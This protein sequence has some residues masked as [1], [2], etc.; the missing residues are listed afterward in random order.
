MQKRLA[1]GLMLALL[2]LYAVGLLLGWGVTSSW[3][4]L[5]VVIAILLLY[6]MLSMRGT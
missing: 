4:L 2:A 1:W 6:N 5:L 3:H